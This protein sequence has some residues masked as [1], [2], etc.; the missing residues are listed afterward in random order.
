M[1]D[2]VN[3]TIARDIEGDLD[4]KTTEEKNMGLFLYLIVLI[5]NVTNL[6]SPVRRAP[7]SA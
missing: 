5:A 3:S 1:V 6:K 4:S 7:E 2:I